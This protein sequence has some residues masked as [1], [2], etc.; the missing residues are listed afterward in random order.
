[1]TLAPARASVLFLV[2][3]AAGLGP[4]LGCE[5][6]PGQSDLDAEAGVD[7]G[8][9]AAVRID[10]AAL[11]DAA[12][13]DAAEPPVGVPYD[14]C[15]E[16]FFQLPIG[17]PTEDVSTSF[18]LWDG[19]LAYSRGPVHSGF[20][21][22][23]YTFNLWQ[24]MEYKITDQAHAGGVYLRDS[25]IL[26]NENRMFRREPDYHCMDL[27]RYDLETWTIEQLTDHPLCEWNPQTNGRYL[28]YERSIEEDGQSPSPREILLWD[29]QE[30]TEQRLVEP[31]AVAGYHDITDRYVAWSGYTQLADSLG[32]DVFYYDL[33]TGQE[34]HVP[35]SA[36]YYCYDVRI[37]GDYLVYVCSEYWLQWPYHLF[38][39]HIPSG[40]ELHLDGAEQPTRIILGGAI[41]EHLVIWNTTKHSEPTEF[42]EVSSDVEIYDLETGVYRRLTT[43]P[44][45]LA[46]VNIYYPF[47]QFTRPL[48]NYVNEYYVGDLEALGV[49][50]ATGNVIP[51]DPVID[52]PQ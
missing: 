29:R 5:E 25:E 43:A 34:T 9:D 50:D 30:D 49:V 22:D 48:G 41:H 15:D 16:A 19:V 35:N 14:F 20:Q 39:H 13:P 37:W 52:P 28:V 47:V 18:G 23:I 12:P 4:V 6:P 8:A 40:E 32:R 24:C 11:P 42:G 26:W 38:L 36:N 21:L 17:G 1:M 7:V 3:L 45:T 2:A 27:F 31:G 44:S 10:V 46:A 51:G 33:E